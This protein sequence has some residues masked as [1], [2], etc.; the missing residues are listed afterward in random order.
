MFE[1]L[2][3]IFESPRIQF[4]AVGTKAGGI[5][6]FFNPQDHK[7]IN[8][9]NTTQNFN[10]ISDGWFD[11]IFVEHAGNCRQKPLQPMCAKTKNTAGETGYE[12]SLRFKKSLCS[13]KSLRYQKS[14]CCKESMCCQEP[15]RCKK[16][17]GVLCV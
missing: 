15:V 14:V 1:C 2:I 12:K 6:K 5:Q 4:P 7:E 9:E 8:H 13:Q 16:V 3:L 10:F 11:G 17:L